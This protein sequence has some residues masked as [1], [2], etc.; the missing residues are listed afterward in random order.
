VLCK[1]FLRHCFVIWKHRSLCFLCSSVCS[2]DIW[3][4]IAFGIVCHRVR[5]K[6]VIIFGLKL[7]IIFER[8][9]ISGGYGIVGWGV[10]RSSLL[11]LK[12]IVESLICS[13]NFGVD[14]S[15]KTLRVQLLLL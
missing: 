13:R 4:G 1:G 9:V 10:V 14:F 8:G 11:V 3:W 6:Y 5:S 7:T 12:D 2:R 15:R